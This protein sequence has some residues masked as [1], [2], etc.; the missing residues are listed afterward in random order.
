MR[1]FY[2]FTPIVVAA[3][4]TVIIRFTVFGDDCNLVV[5]GMTFVIL[6]ALIY[7][8]VILFR[9]LIARLYDGGTDIHKLHE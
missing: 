4:I 9:M 5:V 6:L 1:Y 8:A 3:V 7:G 2:R